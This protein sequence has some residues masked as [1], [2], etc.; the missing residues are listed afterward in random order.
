MAQGSLALTGNDILLYVYV[1]DSP[2][3]IAY[4]TEHSHESSKEGIDL[5]HKGSRHAQ[6]KPGRE[7][8]SISLSLRRLQP[9]S[10][11]ATH[12]T[13]RNAYDNNLPITLQEVVT[14]PGAAADGSDDDVRE[15]EGYIL[16]YNSE[17]P[18]ND[19]ATYELEVTLIEALT[20]V[21]FAATVASALSIGTGNAGVRY[22]ADLAGADGN[23]I[24]VAHVAATGAN[25]PTAVAVAGR[26]I[27]VT[28]GT[29]ATAGTATA[30]A[31][32]VAA[33]VNG[34]AAASA[35]VTAFPLGDGTG[36]VVAQALT[37]LSGGA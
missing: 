15:A 9:N 22:A 5:S 18:D 19:A 29:G 37:Y 10:G 2:E 4:Q 31:T 30:T 28:L 34:N 26:D 13:L 24:R 32:Q 17:A 6:V 33:A 35:L 8:G 1:G 11:A 21:P 25:S 14:F 27:T 12:E 36:V 7:E 23:T 16:S 20:L 3:P